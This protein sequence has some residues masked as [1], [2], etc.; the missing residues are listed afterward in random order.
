MMTNQ[1]ID[2]KLSTL[3]TLMVVGNSVVTL[4]LLA[5][6][7]PTN[8]INEAEALPM[9]TRNLQDLEELEINNTQ[10]W[11]WQVGDEVETNRRNIEYEIDADTLENSPSADLKKEDQEW[12]NLHRGDPR[13]S[14]GGFSITE[15]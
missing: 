13:N 12:Q 14:G 7:P 1:L 3:I 10:P 15:F 8:T 6:Q 4:P 5:N 2:K 11:Q 9:P